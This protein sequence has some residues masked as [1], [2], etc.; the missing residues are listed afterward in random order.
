[1]TQNI[2][3][4]QAIA[5]IEKQIELDARLLGDI[6]DSVKVAVGINVNNKPPEPSEDVVTLA[7]VF[8]AEQLQEIP[9]PVTRI[10]GIKRYL[11]ASAQ[12]RPINQLTHEG[13]QAIA[14]VSRA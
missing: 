5:S 7:H 14:V 1:M 3:T 6:S 12:R 13:S 2:K 8:T 11:V 4:L 9:Q 10:Q